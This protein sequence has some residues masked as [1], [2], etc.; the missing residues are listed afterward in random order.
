MSERRLDLD[1]L[2][3]SLGLSASD[4]RRLLAGALPLTV[5]IA[6][7]LS[8]TV[9]GTTEFWLTREAQYQ[10]DLARVQADK[11]SQGLPVAQMVK[12]GWM[13][14]PSSWVDQI[15]ECL[16]FFD[17]PDIGTWEQRYDRQVEAA[18][19]RSSPSF[20]LEAG[21]TTAWFRAGDLV[22]ESRADLP[23]FDSHALNELLPRL[24]D[25]TRVPQPERF[26][27]DLVRLCAGAGLHVV[28]LP[29]PKGCSASG[30]ARR[31]GQHPL[32][33]LSARHLTD[34]HLWFTFFHEVGH[35]L[36]HNLEMPFIDNLDDREDIDGFEEEANDF[37][38]EFL[39]GRAPI[40]RGA[41]DRR[42]IIRTAH[43][44]SIS[45]GIVVGQLQHRG[46]LRREQF[47]YLKRRYVWNGTTLET[48]RRS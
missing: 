28:V 48:R 30:V 3:P 44:N 24:R 11:W 20:D 8:T 19:F 31:L 40:S 5:A 35:V 21:A 27:G 16:R 46:L 15:D 47:N 26:V 2:A 14:K 22:A 42:N 7:N 39:I 34:D 18:H 38:S 10:D 37:A 33:Q 6:R 25:L 23:P 45:P 43:A 29:T 9:G 1:D 41:L 4:A 17:V 32:I 12:F 13:E 36:R